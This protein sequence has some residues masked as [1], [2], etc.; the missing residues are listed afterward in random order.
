MGSI[1]LPFH[2]SIMKAAIIYQ[3]NSEIM[4]KS[5][6]DF[7]FEGSNELQCSIK[8]VELELKNIGEHFIRIVSLMPGMTKVE[9][10][11]Q[12]SNYVVITTNE[13]IMKRTNILADIEAE[14]IVLEFDE[15][16]KAGKT[17]TTNSHYFHEFTLSNQR[18]KHHMVISEV[19][20]PGLMGF[21]Y[22]NL[23]SNNIGKSFL[24]SYKNF[25]EKQ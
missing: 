3:I 20:A 16:Y 9:L 21:F 6:K 4:A 24:N 8:N 22:K 25:F 7:W 18:V 19:K 11:E 13:G 17:I 10:M 15:E 12:E 5:S 14:K 2:F 23:G 1:I